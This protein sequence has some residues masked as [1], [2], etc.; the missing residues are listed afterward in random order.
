MHS[1]PENR[2]DPELGVERIVPVVRGNDPRGLLE[3]RK[4][5]VHQFFGKSALLLIRFRK[6]EGVCHL[7]TAEIR[8]FKMR[9]VPRYGKFAIQGRRQKRNRLIQHFFG[10]RDDLR[11]FFVV[12]FRVFFV[13]E[14]T[15]FLK[16]QHVSFG[17]HPALGKNS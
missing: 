10:G 8:F 16:G 1:V 17:A 11:Q 4:E 12:E 7:T 13:K 9:A 5:N 3:D 14:Q 6:R 15:E 2:G